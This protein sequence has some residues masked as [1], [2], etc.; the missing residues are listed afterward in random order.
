MHLPHGGVLTVGYGN[1]NVQE[2]WCEITYDKRILVLDNHRIRVAYSPN[3]SKATSICNPAN[4]H[5]HRLIANTIFTRHESQGRARLSEVFLLWCILQGQSFDT[6][7]FLL[8]ELLSQ[9]SFSKPP[10]TY[11][12]VITSI[13][14]TWGLASQVT[15][16]QP[17]LKGGGS[18]WPCVF[19]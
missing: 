15:L 6:E 16:L 13:A 18:V 12:G 8:Q 4:R 1:F 17:L 19:K 7:A 9:A 10:I 5:L 2:F 11:G 14:Y 3:G